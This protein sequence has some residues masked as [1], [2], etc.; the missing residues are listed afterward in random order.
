ML[1]VYLHKYSS[2]PDKLTADFWVDL[3]LGVCGG[4]SGVL[5]V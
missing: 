5:A 2:Q 4:V 3:L 1:K